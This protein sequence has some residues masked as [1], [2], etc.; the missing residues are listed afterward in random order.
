MLYKKLN[1]TPLVYSKNCFFMRRSSFEPTFKGCQRWIS[2]QIMR[3]LTHRWLA[4]EG[5]WKNCWILDLF[6]FGSAGVRSRLKMSKNDLPQT[7]IC[8]YKYVVA[9]YVCR[10]SLAISKKNYLRAWEWF[11]KSNSLLTVG[12]ITPSITPR[13]SRLISEKAASQA[14]RALRFSPRVCKTGHPSKLETT[15]WLLGWNKPLKPHERN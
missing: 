13:S 5:W 11:V 3:T 15:S 2:L 4:G 8:K 10:K 1:W 9:G 14:T 6:F 7:R 12:P